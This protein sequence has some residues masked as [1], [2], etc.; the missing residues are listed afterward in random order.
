[1]VDGVAASDTLAVLG[2]GEELQVEPVGS[3]GHAGG[4][5]SRGGKPSRMPLNS[6]IVQEQA[7]FSL[8]SWI[9]S[10]QSGQ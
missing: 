3:G 9:G 4:A 7:T 6:Q 8:S 2:E 10:S 1:V 5:A